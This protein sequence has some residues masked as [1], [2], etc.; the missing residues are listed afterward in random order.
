MAK[1]TIY[2]MTTVVPGLIKIGKTKTEN[3]ENRMY[4]LERNGYNNVSGLKRRFAIEVDDYDEKES[5][6]DEIFAKSNV[7][8]SELFAIDVEL[9]IQLLSSFEGT[10]IYPSTIS[11]NQVFDKA[12][13]EHKIKTDLS[14]IPDGKY[15]LNQTSKEVG[16]ISAVMQVTNG[17]FIVKKGCKCLPV[18]SAWKP[19]ARKS[20]SIDKNNILLKDVEVSSPSTAGWIVLGHAT[21]GWTIWKDKNNNPIDIYRKK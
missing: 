5:L 1:G 20:A 17:K 13:K 10:Q 19:E 15:Y 6:L 16:E 7:E 11:K 12:T 18:K 9:A 2:I 3:F 4:N 14:L 8:N 21:N